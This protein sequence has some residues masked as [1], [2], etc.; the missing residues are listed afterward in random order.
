MSRKH[1][2]HNLQIQEN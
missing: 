1:L 2:E